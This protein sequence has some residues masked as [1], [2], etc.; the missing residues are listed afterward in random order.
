MCDD[1]DKKIQSIEDGKTFIG[2]ELGSTRIKAVLIGEDH[3]PLATGCREWENQLINGIW[4]YSF[5]EIIEGLQGCFASLS[6]EVQKKYGVALKTAGAMGISA[7]MHGYLA[8]GG[9]SKPLVPFR[10]WRNT[11]TGEAAKK[12]TE[13]F[14]CNIPQRWSIAHLYQA[15]LDAEAHVPEITQLTTLAAYIHRKLTGRKVIGIG[16]AS[17]MFPTDPETGTY[18]AGMVEQFDSLV[19]EKHYPWKLENILP[20]VLS[21]GESAGTLTEEGARLLD[22]TG[23][24]KAGI[25]FCPPEGDAGTGMVATNSVKACTGNVSA[26]TSVFAMVVLEKPL[27]GV[28]PEIDLVS[29]PAGRAVA[30]VHCN[31]CTGDIDAWM[32]L[33]GEFAEAAGVEMNKDSLYKLMYNKALDGESDCGGLLS[34]NYYSGEPVTGFTEGRPLFMRKP[35][36]RFTLANFMRAQLFAALS[37]LR[38]GLNILVD[39]EDVKIDSITGHGGFFRTG[40]VG[41]Y[42]MASSLNTPV[43]VMD[44]AGEGGP[45]GMAIL[46][47]YMKMKEERETLESYLESKVFLNS[48]ST[49]VAP[50]VKD[51]EGFGRFFK[52][53]TKALEVEKTAVTCF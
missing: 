7:M 9:D 24:L 4:T 15:I 51:V 47:A 3:L 20:E 43:T 42:L 32:R 12:L 41:Q 18:N 53:Y 29:T 39:R 10:T 48:I 45:W 36:S 21:A 17:G 26:G 46:A 8:F 31:N 5:D 6:A 19:A 28:Y 1:R 37:S 14:N 25:P 16:D 30:M 2:V 35:D 13:L 49:A 34:Y 44:M 23:M 40:F 38:V 33:F 22:P 50:D 27:S 52:E 11:T